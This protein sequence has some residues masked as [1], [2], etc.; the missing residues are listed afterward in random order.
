MRLIFVKVFAQAQCQPR[1]TQAS[2]L[3]EDLLSSIEGKR[4]DDILGS[5]RMSKEERENF[6]F[7]IEPVTNN[8]GN[9]SD[10]NA[11]VET[12]SNLNSD[13]VWKKE[14]L[15]VLQEIRNDLN[16]SILKKLSKAVDVESFAKSEHMQVASVLNR[17]SGIACIIVNAIF[18]IITW[19][20]FL[21]E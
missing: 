19:I 10:N 2:L 4:I 20:K 15:Q 11:P 12:T 9:N 3:M 18:L 14:A 13:S 7:E 21:S 17:E 8:P 6:G 1:Q 5:Q 16:Y